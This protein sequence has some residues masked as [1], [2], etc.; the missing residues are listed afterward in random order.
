MANASMPRDNILI[1]AIDLQK[2]FGG[3]VALRGANLAVRSGTIHA[4]VGENGAGKST[5]LGAIAGRLH[6]DSGRSPLPVRT[7]RG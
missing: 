6:V 4:L 7:R 1:E 2:R 5:A 3:I